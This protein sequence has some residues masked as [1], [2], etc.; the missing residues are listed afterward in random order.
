MST[1][2]GSTK[3]EIIMRTIG[4][5]CFLFL[6]SHF[7][8]RTAN[9]ENNEIDDRAE[10]AATGIELR[11]SMRISDTEFRKENKYCY[12]TGTLTN[13]S[14]SAIRYYKVG[15]N[16]EDKAGNVID[17]HW[18]NSADRLAPGESDRFKKM[19]ECPPKVHSARIEVLEVR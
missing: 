10:A 5:L 8:I 14:N 6:M 3:F 12:I 11:E 16:L 2:S 15:I 18:T 4:T 17:K 13:G 9:K 7:L 19:A 1:Q